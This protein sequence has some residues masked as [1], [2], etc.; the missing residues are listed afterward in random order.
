MTLKLENPFKCR[1][2]GFIYASLSFCYFFFT[3]LNGF[4]SLFQRQVQNAG[5]RSQVIVLPIQKVSLTFIKANLR[6]RNFS[7]GLIRPKISLLGLRLAFMN[8]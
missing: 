4:K 2:F 8:D 1:P 7:L 6:P 5:H 3:L